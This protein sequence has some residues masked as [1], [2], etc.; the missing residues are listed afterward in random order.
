MSFSAFGYVMI[1]GADGGALEN[2][3]TPSL[4]SFSVPAAHDY[5]KKS[6]A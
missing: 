1:S 6:C 3:S 4:E 2:K 5:P